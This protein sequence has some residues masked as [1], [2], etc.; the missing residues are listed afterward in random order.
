MQTSFNS[1]ILADYSGTYP[2]PGYLWLLVGRLRLDPARHKTFF[3][4]KLQELLCACILACE[5]LF[6]DEQFKN[7]FKQMMAAIQTAKEKDMNGCAFDEYEYE[8]SDQR[9]L[10]F[11][12]STSIKT[13]SEWN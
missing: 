1:S 7:C 5:N 9:E 12:W 6:K 4:L 8:F 2:Q 13:F 11:T 3:K 10:L